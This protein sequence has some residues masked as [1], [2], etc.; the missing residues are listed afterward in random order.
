[1]VM[2]KLRKIVS[3]LTNLLFSSEN[4]Q[5]SNAS[6]GNCRKAMHAEVTSK[7]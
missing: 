5:K 2:E 4:P 6:E 7:V 1:M 3:A